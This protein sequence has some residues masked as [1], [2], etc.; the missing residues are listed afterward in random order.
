VQRLEKEKELL[1]EENERVKTQI[2]NLKQYQ[3]RF[4]NISPVSVSQSEL[5]P[6]SPPPAPGA[7][8]LL[9]AA[10]ATAA[11]AAASLGLQQA[12]P[13]ATPSPR[14]RSPTGAG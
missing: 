7:T 6:R 8:L 3:Y 1:C 2:L 4:H 11:A 10:V 12:Y 14:L 13:A 5:V 9:G